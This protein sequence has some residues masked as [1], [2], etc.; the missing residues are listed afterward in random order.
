MARSRSGTWLARLLSSLG[1]PPP[2]PRRHFSA[3]SRPAGRLTPGGISSRIG[4]SG[5]HGGYGDGSTGGHGG[6]PGGYSGGLP[7]GGYGGGST[8]GHG[9]PPG[10]YGGGSPGG[11]GAATAVAASRPGHGGRELPRRVGARLPNDIKLSSYTHSIS[12]QAMRHVGR[13]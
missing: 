11:Y 10:G 6:P 8:G 9:G 3:R 1:P 13:A 4:I 2:P 5:H 12:R 7:G